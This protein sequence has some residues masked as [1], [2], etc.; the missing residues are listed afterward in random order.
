MKIFVDTDKVAKIVKASE[1]VKRWDFL[2]S[3][4]AKYFKKLSSNFLLC[5]NDYDHC[6]TQDCEKCD[7]KDRFDVAKFIKKCGNERR[8]N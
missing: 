7:G 4:L 2:V 3:D 1:K 6:E 5:Y 8:K